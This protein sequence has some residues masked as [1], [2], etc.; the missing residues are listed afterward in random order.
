MQDIIKPNRASRY[1]AVN[2]IK[3]FNSCLCCE[4]NV[5]APLN[6]QVSES[7]LNHDISRVYIDYR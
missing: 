1:D 6:E 7:E 4:I 3:F 5:F 2:M